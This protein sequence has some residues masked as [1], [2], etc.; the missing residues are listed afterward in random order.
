MKCFYHPQLDAVAVCKNCGRGVCQEDAAD[1]GNGIACKGRCEDRLRASN[2]LADRNL[3]ISQRAPTSYSMSFIMWV[4]VGI[5]FI[6][7]GSSFNSSPLIALISVG[8]GLFFIGIGAYVYFLRSKMVG[9][10]SLD[11]RQK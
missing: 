5:L 11:E 1:V 9:V 3:A 2:L 6:G 8:G 10:S 4:I 7:I